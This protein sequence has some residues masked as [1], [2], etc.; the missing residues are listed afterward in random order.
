MTQRLHECRSKAV[1]AMTAQDQGGQF[2]ARTEFLGNEVDVTEFQ[3][4]RQATLQEA[5]RSGPSSD[6]WQ[7]S[8]EEHGLELDESQ[9]CRAA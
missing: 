7:D 3:L 9:P 6:P 5:V 8:L 4:A 2:R 1:A